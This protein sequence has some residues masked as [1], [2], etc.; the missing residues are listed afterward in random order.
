M[1]EYNGMIDYLQVGAKMPCS[2]CT[3]T[4]L[5]AG[6]EYPNGSYANSNTSLWL[7]HIVLITY[8]QEDVVCGKN[9][10]GQG[11]RWFASGNERT[12]GD[13]SRG[14]C[15]HRNRLSSD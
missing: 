9:F 6:L 13:I 14:G 12:P 4:Y 15:V 11:R 10:Y 2:N 7:H 5:K 8:G 3:I 1:G